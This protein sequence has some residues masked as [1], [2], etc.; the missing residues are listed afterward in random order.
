MT[1]CFPVAGIRLGTTQAGIRYADRRDL[2][3]IEAVPGSQAAAVFTR[4]AFCAAP[5]T[6]A[7]AHLAQAMPRYLVIN[8]GNANAGTGAAGLDDARQTCR[9]VARLGHC[10]EQEVLPFST[11][12]IGER[13]PM[14]RLLAGLPDALAALD[15]SGWD[16]AAWGILTT[17]TRPKRVSRQCLIDGQT[18]TLS[19]IAK[20]SG[21][22]RPDMATMLAF[23]ATDAEIAPELLQASLNQAVAMSFNAITIDGDTSTN[24]ACVLLATRQ[25]GLKI[26]QQD[27][28]FETFST[29]LRDVCIELAQGLVRD[30]EGASKFITIQVEQGNSVDECRQV[31]FTVAHSPLVKTAFFAS[32]PNWGRILAAVGRAGLEALVVDHINIYLDDV[33][34][35]RGGGRAEDYTEQRGQIAMQRDD[36]TV[37]IELGRGTAQAQVWTSDLSYDYVKINAEYRS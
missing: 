26:A 21:M 16:D 28:R 23:I 19:G 13:L 24:D 20:G 27:T 34:I 2:V 30:G 22:I 35:V 6:V 4:N 11:G 15:D 3:V 9:E 36:I 12:V 17:D 37:T 29:L 18:V 8:T 33:C 5:I 25:S 1:E 32:D 31:A 10:K 7:Q 14:N